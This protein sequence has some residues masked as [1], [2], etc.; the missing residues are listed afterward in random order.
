M[1]LQKMRTAV[2]ATSLILGSSAFTSVF[3]DPPQAQP[4]A[5][6]QNT[7]QDQNQ[8]QDQGRVILTPTNSNDQFTHVAG[9]NQNGEPGTVYRSEVVTND[10][11]VRVELIAHPRFDDSANRK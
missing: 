5:A 2:M 3:A 1:K 4:V 7:N 10:G 11:S 6:D 8:S 9:D